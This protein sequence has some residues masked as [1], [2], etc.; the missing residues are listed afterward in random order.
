MLNRNKLIHMVKRILITCAV[1]FLSTGIVSAQKQ[2]VDSLTKELTKNLADTSKAL[3]LMRLAI[4][5]ENLDT[6]KSA[7]F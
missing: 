1:I 2:V 4:A 3:D 5:F 7:H 6:S